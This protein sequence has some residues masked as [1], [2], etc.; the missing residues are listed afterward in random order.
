MK[1]NV[2]T[3]VV[4]FVTLAGISF[5]FNACKKETPSTS[6]PG[7]YN[8]YMTD[9]PGAYQQVNVNIVGA[10]ANTGGSSWVALKVNAGIYN[11]LNFSN[12]RD[13]LI[14]TGQLSGSSVT[15]VRL[16]LGST[17]NTVMVNNTVYPLQTSAEEQSGLTV[18][19]SSNMSGSS[20]GSVVL[21]FDA[22]MSVVA[23][24]SGS[25]TLKPVVRANIPPTNGGIKGTVSV[26]SPITAVLAI[27]GSDT[28]SGFSS[29]LSGGF[30]LQGLASGTYKVV[31]I[32]PPP[33][34]MST[35]ANVNVSSG[36]VTD[37][38]SITLQ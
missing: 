29:L 12:G 23:T 22:G 20:S 1:T 5:L 17:G 10:E 8:M 37:M 35:V 18:N 9:A 3:L 30:M 24:G 2:K 33:Y 14:A 21:D 38:G 34:S 32:P 19:V 7:T 4:M 26:L 13:T 25:Y 27:N 31:I 28:A 16:L 11:L 6:S 36:Q 15:Q